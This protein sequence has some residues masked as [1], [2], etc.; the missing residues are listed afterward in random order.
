MTFLFKQLKQSIINNDFET[1][2]IITSICQ[3]ITGFEFKCDY[4]KVFFNNITPDNEYMLKYLIEKYGDIFIHHIETLIGLIFCKCSFDMFK[5]IDNIY[6]EWGK[7]GNNII[8]YMFQKKLNE[9]IGDPSDKIL[10]YYTKYPTAIK[11]HPNYHQIQ[12]F[13]LGCFFNNIQICKMSENYI[14]HYYIG[15]AVALMNNSHDVIEYINTKHQITFDDYFEYYVRF[16]FN[17]NKI[18]DNFKKHIESHELSDKQL[19][20]LYDRNYSDGNVETHDYIYKKFNSDKFDQKCISLSYLRED[21]FKWYIS[22]DES[23]INKFDNKWY[24]SFSI[25]YNNIYTYK[26]ILDKYNF[27]FGEMNVMIYYDMSESTNILKID[28][29]ETKYFL[30]KY[31]K[32]KFIELFK[33]NDIKLHQ[34]FLSYY[35]RHNNHRRDVICSHNPTKPSN[36]RNVEYIYNLGF[37]DIIQAYNNLDHKKDKYDPDKF[38]WLYKKLKHNNIEIDESKFKEAIKILE[39]ENYIFDTFMLFVPKDNVMYDENVFRIIVKS[40]LF[41]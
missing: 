11:N 29:E 5:Y 41:Y 4:E 23:F 37:I 10:F 7:N 30:N 21:I 39:F 20:L 13:T 26:I 16:S 9:Y 15:Y 17:Y 14:K 38:L 34:Y 31:G 33:V 36:L 8:P 32:D 12:I 3:I 19:E 18:D 24:T 35:D 6:P 1:F 40:Y 27:T 28:I 22:L 25:A 2:K